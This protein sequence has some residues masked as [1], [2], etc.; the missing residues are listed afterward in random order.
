MRSSNTRSILFSAF[1]LGVLMLPGER[2]RSACAGEPLTLVRDGKP[3]AALVLGPQPTRVAEFAALELQYHVRLITGATLPVVKSNRHPPG[4]VILVGDSPAVRALGVRPEVM[5]F[6]QYLVRFYPGAVVLVGHDSP[7]RGELVYD[8]SDP[9]TGKGWPDF[10]DER[11]TLHAVYDFLER[12]CGVRWFNQTEFGTVYRRRRTLTVR[13]VRIKRAPAFEFR[14]ALGALGDN[15]ARYDQYV[16]LWTTA[17][18]GFNEWTLAAYPSL[19]ARYGSGAKFDAA[20]ANLARLFALRMRDGGK[21]CRCNHSLYGYYDRFWEKNPGRPELFVAK[22]P[23]MFAKG[24]TGKPPQLCYTSPELVQQLA[25]DARD[26]YAGKVTGADLGIFWGPHLP[27][28][29]PVEPMDN[30]SFCKCP[31]CQAL[32]RQA[33]ENAS[34]FSRG[35]HSDYFFHFVNEVCNEL[36]KTQPHK[37]IV[38]L[39]YMT[40]AR[41]PSFK[42]NP[43]VIIQF[44]F[45]ANR[46]PYSNNYAHEVKLLKQWVREGGVRP[47]YLWLYDTFPREHAINGKYHCFPG[48]FAHTLASQMKLFKKLGIRGMF[49]C[50]YGQEVEA[51]LTFKLMDDPTLNVDNLLDDYFSGLYGKAGRPL[52]AM[53]LDI[54]KTYGNPALRPK[55]RLSGPALNWGCLGTARRMENYASWMREAQQLADGPAHKANVALFEKAVW[56]Y[57]VA[58]RKQFVERQQAPIP[59]V[60]V[61][62]VPPAQGDPNRVAWT[63]ATSLGGPWYERG[64]DRPSRRRFRGRIAHD[65][66]YLYLELT[67]PCNTSQLTTSATVFPFDDWEL[68]LAKQRDLPYRQYAWGPTGLVKALS[69]GE[70]NFRLNVPL[71]NP[72]IRVVSDITAPNRWVSRVAVPLARALPGGVRAG[73]T[74]YLNLIRVSSPGIAKNGR[75][76]GLDTWVSFCTVHEVDRLGRLTLAK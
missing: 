23:G 66:A 7:A 42:L 12:C 65:G 8:M 16:A 57:M 6:E 52:K 59:S 68:F 18:P 46:A 32:I 26:Y 55:E 61:P 24:Y 54:E 19:R 70:V 60:T 62:R 2:G 1:V 30:S 13:P 67:D 9:A 73:D 44:C 45:T 33:E 22:R 4:T 11:G 15:P 58:G 64:G 28:P 31:R 17:D 38:A 48:F 20:R 40:H 75:R 53:Y 72:G 43:N 50:G 5:T 51:Y 56:E 39:A 49:H 74:I 63:L 35:T 69:H 36:N 10:W 71:E 21:L 14:D 41:I 25:Q 47:L 29:F 76:L 34:A 27:N 37:R 3:E